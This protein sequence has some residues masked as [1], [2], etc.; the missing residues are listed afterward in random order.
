MHSH[1][2]CPAGLAVGYRAGATATVLGLPDAPHRRD[3]SP[4]DPRPDAQINS[5]PRHHNQACAHTNPIAVILV[6]THATIPPA[7]T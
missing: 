7:T 2:D 3:H 4:L 5:S 6:A 1:L